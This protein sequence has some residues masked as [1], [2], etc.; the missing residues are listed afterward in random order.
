[1]KKPKFLFEFL[2][3]E[4]PPS[5]NAESWSVSHMLKIS[6]NK[7][8]NTMGEKYFWSFTIILKWEN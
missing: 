8:I 1:M 2:I 4:L 3:V 5:I 7:E 6:N